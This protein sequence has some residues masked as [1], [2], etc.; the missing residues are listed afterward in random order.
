MRGR[1]DLLCG[2]ECDSYVRDAGQHLSLHDVSHL[3]AK[4]VAPFEVDVPERE[5][6]LVQ[7]YSWPVEESVVVD[8]LASDGVA[9]ASVSWEHPLLHDEADAGEGV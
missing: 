4:A 7:V 2:S 6:A 3:D 5:S 1:G 8:E 9:S